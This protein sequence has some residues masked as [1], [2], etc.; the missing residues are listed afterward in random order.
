V[1][2][3]ELFK[4]RA[5]QHGQSMTLYPF[6]AH[7]SGTYVDSD[8]GY[9]DPESASYPAAVPSDAYG[10]AVT[11][12]GFVQPPT[13]GRTQGQRYVKTVE[14]EEVAVELVAFLPGD[15]A[16]TVRDKLTIGGVDYAVLQIGD[17]QDGSAIIVRECAL[18]K[19][20]P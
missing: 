13:G 2:K 15:Q 11:V 16:V 1:N 3:L 7:P 5:S 10:T 19:V 12:L 4:L 20:V 18:R 17:S 6:S 14:G 8:S 9:P